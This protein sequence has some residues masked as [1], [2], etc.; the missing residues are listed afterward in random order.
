[1]LVAEPPVE[2][3]STDRGA[4]EELRLRCA[5]AMPFQ[6][7]PLRVPRAPSWGLGM[8]RRHPMTDA[9][10]RPHAILVDEGQPEGMSPPRIPA[11]LEDH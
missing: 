4:V 9:R 6:G 8:W 11:V 10:H 7:V 1:M 2:G 3:A 5:G